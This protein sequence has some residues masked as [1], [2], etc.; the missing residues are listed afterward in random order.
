[1]LTNYLQ[2]SNYRM[3]SVEYNKVISTSSILYIISQ[4]SVL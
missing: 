4:E 2:D 1:M 3:S